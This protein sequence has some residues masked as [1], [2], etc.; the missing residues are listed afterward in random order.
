MQIPDGYQFHEARV[1]NGYDSTRWHILVECRVVVGGMTFSACP[2]EGEANSLAE[3]VAA[4][5]TKM[6]EVLPPAQEP[7][8]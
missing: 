4:V 3:A 7:K 1:Y 5:N 8:G 2:C 6:R